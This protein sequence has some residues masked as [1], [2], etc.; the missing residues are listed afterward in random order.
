MLSGWN[1]WS[2]VASADAHIPIRTARDLIRLERGASFIRRAHRA[3]VRLAIVGLLDVENAKWQQEI[4]SL[5]LECGCRAA[6]RE[7]LAFILVACAY[8]LIEAL[9]LDLGVTHR[10][11]VAMERVYCEKRA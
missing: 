9:R 5:R 2:S 8:V 7:L 6:I 10:D 3:P 1:T 4:Q 11:G